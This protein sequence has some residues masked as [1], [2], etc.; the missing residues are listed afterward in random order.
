MTG[1][2][3]NDSALFLKTGSTFRFTFATT[4]TQGMQSPAPRHKAELR[5]KPKRGPG[6]S[7]QVRSRERSCPSCSPSRSRPLP[8]LQ[9]GLR[10]RC[11]RGGRSAPHGPCPPG[12]PSAGCPSPGGSSRPART[13]QPGCVRAGPGGTAARCPRPACSSP[14]SPGYRASP[15]VL[16]PPSPAP[17]R[18][19]LRALSRPL[20]SPPSPG[21]VPAL[22]GGRDGTE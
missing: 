21:A 1:K 12:P 16:H 2:A 3:P 20:P 17:P 10:C 11:S 4:V 9:P 7:S 13:A 15:S 8:A 22:R 19:T 18:G 14:P 5:L 6:C